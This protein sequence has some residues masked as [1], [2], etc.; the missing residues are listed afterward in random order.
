MQQA[1]PHT[2]LP[3]VGVGTCIYLRM[4]VATIEARRPPTQSRKVWGG[5]TPTISNFPTFLT[6]IPNMEMKNGPFQEKK[7]TISGEFLILG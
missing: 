1:S 4:G 6:G 3:V 5:R 7:S 2:F